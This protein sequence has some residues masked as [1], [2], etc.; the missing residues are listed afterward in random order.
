MQTALLLQGWDSAA[1][2]CD[3]ANA[4]IG[5]FTPE[6]LDGQKRLP[7]GRVGDTR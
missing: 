4:D 3:G 1:I 2:E 7:A 5:S 6:D